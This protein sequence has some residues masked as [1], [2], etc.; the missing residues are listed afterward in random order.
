MVE[1]C[2]VHEQCATSAD[3]AGCVPLL[4]GCSSSAMSSKH[5][6]FELQVFVCA[7]CGAQLT[8]RQPHESLVC[9]SSGARI[10]EG[11]PGRPE[12]FDV[13]AHTIELRFLWQITY[14]YFGVVSNR[15]DQSFSCS[16]TAAYYAAFRSLF[17][18]P[19]VQQGCFHAGFTR[20]VR[21]VSAQHSEAYT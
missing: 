19:S 12:R 21:F 15:D 3:G 11:G 1:M 10:G 20:V 5:L 9:T 2:E 6:A 17:R 14:F 7:L 13:P 18:I 4:L 16:V 8:G